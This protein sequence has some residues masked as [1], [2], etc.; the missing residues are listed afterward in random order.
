[1]NWLSP[2]RPNGPDT[3]TRGLLF[4]RAIVA[5]VLAV[6]LGSACLAVSPAAQ[7]PAG[8]TASAGGPL[9]I[10]YWGNDANDA[11]YI[12][13][14]IQDFEAQN[15]GIHVKYDK[16]V[17]IHSGG[18]NNGEL[19]KNAEA[20][21]TMPDSW[22][23]YGGS[24]GGRHIDN[25]YAASLDDYATRDGWQQKFN[26]AAL[27]L[28]TYTD[29]HLHG[30]PLFLNCVGFYYNKSTFQRLGLQPPTT[31]PEF[32]V[33]LQKLQGAGL[34]PLSVGGKGSWMTLRFLEGLIETYAGSQQHDK[35][36]TL[37]AAWTDPAVV[38][39]LTKLK[40]WTDKEYFPKGYV[41]LDNN[42]IK[43]L[44]FQG[45][46]GLFLE[47]SWFDRQTYALKLDPREYG[48]F[49]FPTGQ[50]PPRASSFLNW[51]QIN[52]HKPK[53]HQDASVKFA[54]FVSSV[55]TINRHAADMGGPFAAIGAT[56]ADT[57]PH[58]RPIEDALAKGN[59]LI[60][61]QAL[62]QP[63]VQKFEEMQDKVVLG[64]VSPADAAAAIQTAAEDYKKTKK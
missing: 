60:T 19:M 26:P 29:G 34:T 42:E 46:T 25:G 57:A 6:G 43:P 11:A 14:L 17:N 59:W 28:A 33:L 64:D 55:D 35:L 31:L 39:A 30:V 12:E 49:L 51:I 37:N 23:E 20:T 24:I 45:K 10:E 1:M 62:P 61:D 54:E 4:G 18:S 21:D 2:G 36:N 48:M 13:P 56:L 27:K 50:N 15:P 53:D 40:E 5:G 32:E 16:N 22:Y 58:V 44:F 41:S 8:S 47:V 7:P 52:S 3:R 38:Q 63:V 9:T